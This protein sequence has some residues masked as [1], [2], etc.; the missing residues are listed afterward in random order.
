MGGT[1]SRHGGGGGGY[2]APGPHCS[3]GTGHQ[4]KIDTTVTNFVN[5]R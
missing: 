5:P 1:S 4:Y 3:D 2:G